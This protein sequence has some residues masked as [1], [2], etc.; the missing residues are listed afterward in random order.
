MRARARARA[1]SLGGSCSSYQSSAD[2]PSR[3]VCHLGYFG[4]L[5][6]GVKGDKPEPLSH[7][8]G[9]MAG[10]GGVGDIGCTLSVTPPPPLPPTFRYVRHW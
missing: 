8:L 9:R 5:R 10:E 1:A 6:Q 4:G 2:I 3:R 7:A